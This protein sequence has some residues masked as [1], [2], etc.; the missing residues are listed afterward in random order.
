MAGFERL[1]VFD[2]H[3]SVVESMPVSHVVVGVVGGNDSHFH[4]FGNRRHVA[5]SLDIAHD[6][7]LLQLKEKVFL[8]ECLDVFSGGAFSGVGVASGYKP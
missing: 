6:K 1:V 5:V 2:R 7:V 4:L 3:K 8:S